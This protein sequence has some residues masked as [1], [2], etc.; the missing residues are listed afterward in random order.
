MISREFRSFHHPWAAS[1]TK[2][3]IGPSR[4]RSLTISARIR[5]DW[6]E[7]TV[8]T[9]SC[10]KIM[11]PGCSL[12][13]LAKAAMNASPLLLPWDPFLILRCSFPTRPALRKT[14]ETS[15]TDS[16]GPLTPGTPT[17]SPS[18]PMVGWVLTIASNRMCSSLEMWRIW[19]GLWW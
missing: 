17:I 9:S 18:G 6:T 4:R 10:E 11:K 19:P 1:F 14:S 2:P 5:S 7:I 8:T 12:E 15:V 3:L 13:N 16:P